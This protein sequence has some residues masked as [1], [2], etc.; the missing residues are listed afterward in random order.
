M[1]VP[2]LLRN[3]TE[4]PNQTVSEKSPVKSVNNASRVRARNGKSENQNII[5]RLLTTQAITTNIASIKS[6]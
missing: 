6:I 1:R 3:H 2:I 5:T 4:A